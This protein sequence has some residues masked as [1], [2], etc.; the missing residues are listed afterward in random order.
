MCAQ[1]VKEVDPGSLSLLLFARKR[2][3]S[4]EPLREARTG[5]EVFVERHYTMLGAEGE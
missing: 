2:G 1:L 5:P 3:M 4:S